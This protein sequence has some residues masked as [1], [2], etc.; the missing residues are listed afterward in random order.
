[1]KIKGNDLAK[2]FSVIII[3]MFIFS[4]ASVIGLTF[5]PVQ[6]EITENI[7]EPIFDEITEDILDSEEL[8]NPVI[9]TETEPYEPPSYDKSK[10]VWKPIE[11]S[12]NDV[13]FGA[14][15]AIIPELS[16]S[17]DLISQKENV[18][19][20]IED[21]PEGSRPSQVEPYEGLLAEAGIHPEDV[22]GAD[23]R[24][25]V[26]NNDVFPW[27]TVVKLYITA[28]DS[29]T[30]IGSGWI[31]DN[32]HV[33]TAGHCVFLHDH[34]GWASSIEVIPG[35]E[36]STYPYGNA[37]GVY[38]RSYTGWTSSEMP[39]H[40]WA[41]ITLD[42]NVG[43][44]TGWM[45][46]QTASSSSSI[47]TGVMNVAGYP[48]DLDS[49]IYMYTD[50]DNGDGATSYNH[51]YWADTAGGMSGGPVWRF[52]GVNRYIMTVHAYGRGGTDSNYGTRLN[53]DKYDRIFDWLSADTA[54]TD[55]PDMRDRGSAFSSRTPS[56]VTATVTSFSVNCD[57]ENIGTAS[58]GGFYVHFY[59]STN[60]YIST[61]DYLIGY[62]YVSSISA[63]NYADVSWSGTFPEIP[64]GQYYVGWLIDQADTRDEFDESNNQAY[65]SSKI[66]VIGAPPPSG[67]IELT[68]RD[69]ATYLG[70]PSV[71]VRCYNPSM[72]LVDAGYTN[73]N[74]F[75]N[76]TGLDIGDHIIKLTKTE[77]YATEFTNYIN[78]IG[79]DDYRTIYMD[80]MPIDSGYIEVNVKDSG[81]SSPI[82]SA[83]V[84]CYNSTDGTYIK[85]GYTNSAGFYNLTN[86]RV[87]MYDIEV[88]KAGYA[89]KTTS[90]YINWRGDDDYLTFNL[91]QMPPD[92]GYIEVRVFNA[93]STLPV[94]SALVECWDDTATL[95][96][97]GYTNA[98]GFYK[99]TGLYVGWHTINVS[100][101]GFYEQSKTDYINWNGDDDYLSFYLS[102][103]P[104]TSGYIE[105]TVRD[106]VTYDPISSAMIQCLNQSSGEV[107]D[108]G[109][110]D[111]SGK[112]T[113]NG[114]SV[115]WY[116]I[117]ASKGGYKTSTTTDYIN[118]NGDDDYLYLYLEAYPPNSGYTEI[119]V[120]DQDTLD[121][122]ENAFVEC[123]YFSNGTLFYSGYTDV[124][125]F[126]NVTNM[127][128][129]WFNFEITAD[130]YKG[131]I[132]STYINWN[133]DDD[134]LDVYLEP[135]PI[136]SGFIEVLLYDSLTYLPIPT[137][138][139]ECF[140]AS[141]GDLVGKGQTDLSGFFNLTGL[142]PGFYIIDASHSVYEQQSKIT[143]IAWAGDYDH[144][145]FYLDVK[146]FTFIGP[147][148]LFRN[149]LP[150]NLN[151]TEPILEKY[152][153]PYDI[154]NSSDF[155]VVDLSAYKKAII[156]SDQSQAFYDSLA[157]NRTWFESYASN[158]GILEIHG[159]DHAWHSGVWDSYQM[160]GGVNKTY[161]YLDNVSISKFG[162][163]LLLTP[164]MVEDD[165]LD[166]WFYS[167]HG[168]FDNYPSE[169]N[170][171]LEEGASHNP[172]LIEF[173]F[174][175]GFIVITMQTL[176]W[177][178]NLNYTKLLENLVLY[179][180]QVTYNTIEVLNP[181]S[182]DR[183]EITGS[184]S[185][186]WEA[187]GTI[188]DVKIELYVDG[189]YDRIITGSTTNDGRFTWIIPRDLINSTLCQ[190]KIS[191]VSFPEIY[192]FSGYFVIVPPGTPAIPGFD[193]FIMISL[194]SMVSLVMIL[195]KKKQISN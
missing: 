143:Q 36:G 71:Y 86:L 3:G 151:V 4:G 37:W 43:A 142:V 114:L 62:T 20:R 75:Y 57:V 90:D 104:P 187:N 94:G 136:D 78:F 32:F 70:L 88:S 82:T 192:D 164:Y 144:L 148:A 73:S 175:N 55:K 39:E 87:G 131:I 178:Q 182:G 16:S 1:M 111:V 28:A 80:I 74:G 189:V 9:E 181:N 81:T 147:V 172:V 115:G 99:I 97:S 34:G 117:N 185:I 163:A 125:G 56:T 6:T 30:W 184:E 191:D 155:G 79:D 146:T 77:Y 46:R 129:G 66:T 165:E 14:E 180:P 152:S 24:T 124:D 176:E 103:L 186:T 51:F 177:N 54:P 76:I 137:V 2:L 159:A 122:I 21:S 96:D 119:K 183:W 174:G 84:K 156:V 116:T 157:A 95:V 8:M 13:Q 53:N 101:V 67:Y 109:W 158:G 35:M 130:G 31:V 133:G 123:T 153:I 98:S 162:H 128:I 134:Y 64:A 63:F 15:S 69:S 110:T 48:G 27:R 58:S 23:G 26:Y 132:S 160:P 135:S 47:Y 85:G 195:V 29:S 61:S 194:L 106:D 105:V 19:S 138:K 89:T 42:R 140:D 167:T 161:S 188:T 25:R 41:M 100:K 38:Y 112:Y 107:I 83:L 179:Q 113:I 126:F 190:I 169:A 22:I 33:I 10:F 44:Y 59:A 5:F 17:Y 7:D 40:D 18:D 154:Y 139:V 173:P 92:S 102:E 11:E 60:N 49:G 145:T 50:S 68:V 12:I 166:N 65:I 193:V 93:S 108:I 45:G 120:Y 91:V 168:Y 170:V 141:T 72:T 118:W 121:P 171:I 127:P 52:D 149:N 150:W